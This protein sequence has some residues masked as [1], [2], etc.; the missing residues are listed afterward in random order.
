MAIT[1]QD[2]IDNKEKNQRVV[3]ITHIE[4][5]TDENGYPSYKVEYVNPPKNYKLV[6]M[7]TPLKVAILEDFDYVEPTQ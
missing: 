6:K 7:I 3:D 4:N 5:G 1:Q 2:I